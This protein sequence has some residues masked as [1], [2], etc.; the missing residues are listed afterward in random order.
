MSLEGTSRNTSQTKLC[1][2]QIRTPRLRRT[3]EHIPVVRCGGMSFAGNYSLPNYAL[4]S[5]PCM[6]RLLYPLYL[7]LVE[8]ARQ[9]SNAHSLA[10]I[11]SGRPGLA[12]DPVKRDTTQPTACFDGKYPAFPQGARWQYPYD[13]AEFFESSLRF[14]CI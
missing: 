2:Y 4:T 11:S 7:Y 14:F 3:L 12:E 13:I 10:S 5:L 1:S 8:S 6:C 9:L